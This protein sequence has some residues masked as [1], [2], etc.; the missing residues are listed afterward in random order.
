[1]TMTARDKRIYYSTRD[2]ELK[3]P[4]EPDKSDF[5]PFFRLNV[6]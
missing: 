6:R 3:I 1:M 2:L 5:Y 4:A